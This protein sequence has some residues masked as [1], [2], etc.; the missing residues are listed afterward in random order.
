MKKIFC[1]LILFF[2]ILGTACQKRTPTVPE[3]EIMEFYDYEV[4]YIRMELINLDEIDPDSMELIVK[5]VNAVS[6]KLIKIND[7]KFVGEVKQLPTHIRGDHE[8]NRVWVIDPK[9]WRKVIKEP[10]GQAWGI[11]HS[12]GDRIIFKNKQTG[13]TKELQRIV[14][15]PEWAQYE[16]KMA[17][18]FT[19]KGGIITD[20]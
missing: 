20:N 3:Q 16:G 7:Y 13:Y 2:L 19:K 17:E 5:G 11:P 18:F 12:V 1:S 9:R 6:I 15:K 14:T 10:T 4:T 8:P